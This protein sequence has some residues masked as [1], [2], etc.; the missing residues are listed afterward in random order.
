MASSN[1]QCYL[2]FLPSLNFALS[3]KNTSLKWSLLRFQKDMFLSLQTSVVSTLRSKASPYRYQELNPNQTFRSLTMELVELLGTLPLTAW[4]R[5]PPPYPFHSSEV[6]RL[7]QRQQLPLL[8]QSPQC[9]LHFPHCIDSVMA[10]LAYL[11]SSGMQLITWL[12][13]TQLKV[14]SEARKTV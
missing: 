1:I 10:S 7:R 8:G 5:W 11:S 12:T 13:L 4:V 9:S 2:P 6:I 14:P 3:Y